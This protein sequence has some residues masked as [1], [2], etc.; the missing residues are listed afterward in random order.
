MFSVLMSCYKNDNVKFLYDSLL[1]IIHQTLPPD[2]VVL[3]KDGPLS[4]DLDG[5][6][7]IFIDKFPS[8]G[9]NFVLVTLP[10]NLGLGRALQ[11]GLNICSQKYIVRM[12]AD[13]ISRLNRI[14]SLASIIRMNAGIDVLGSQIEEFLESPGDLNRFRIVP[15]EHSEIV[16]FGRLR[17]P[18]N[19]VTVCFKKNV[20][21][22]AG[23]YE[24]MLW[25]E[26][27]F[28]WLKLINQN[29][30]FL[31]VNEVHVD[32]RVGSLTERR[33]GLKYLMAELKFCKEAIR[34]D[35]WTLV[36]GFK[37]ITSRIL[38]RLLP[39]NFLRIIYSKILRVSKIK[40]S[41][42]YTGVSKR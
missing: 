26:D 35:Y 13:D 12:D 36:S 31:N 32:V 29:I 25:L 6:I 38:L 34:R 33:M 3:V 19:H 2:E 40:I 18:M 28:L 24:P 42:K 4:K 23:G 30:R 8:V 41:K 9:I 11:E 22:Q 27:W 5:V 14:E 17:N 15:L 21:I 20:V 39:A 10:I 37:Y 1:S 16:S 7:K